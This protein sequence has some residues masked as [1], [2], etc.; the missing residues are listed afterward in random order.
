MSEVGAEVGSEVR[1][2]AVPETR[3]GGF[4]SSL[5][6]S[7]LRS[8]S[9]LRVALL[10]L[11][12]PRTHVSAMRPITQAVRSGNQPPSGIFTRLA[13]RNAS[14]MRAIGTINDAAFQSGQFQ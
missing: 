4:A 1:N 12:E 6:T 9:F 13:I 14:S 8:A 3:Y 7:Q 10:R 5:R 2:T 11:L